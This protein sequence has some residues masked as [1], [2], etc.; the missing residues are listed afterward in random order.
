MSRVDYSNN[1]RL[2]KKREKI[3]LSP[4]M[5]EPLMVENG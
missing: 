5:V 1:L 2:S 3:I 4:L